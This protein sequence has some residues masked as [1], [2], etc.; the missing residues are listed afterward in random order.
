LK[1]TGLSMLIELAAAL[2]VAATWVV[3][4]NAA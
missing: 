1:A 3:G 2:G 4:L